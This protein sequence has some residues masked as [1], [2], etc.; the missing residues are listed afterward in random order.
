MG[1]LEKNI[2]DK[3]MKN[4]DKIFQILNKTMSENTT[5]F[6]VKLSG[7]HFSISINLN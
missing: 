5:N 7:M 4:L 6:F 2:T 1:K 3:D